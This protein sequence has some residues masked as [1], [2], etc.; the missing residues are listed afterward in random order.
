MSD[1]AQMTARTAMVDAKGMVSRP[2]FMFFDNIRTKVNIL[3]S[4]ITTSATAGAATAL[5]A[6]PEGYITIKLDGEDYKVPF[7][8]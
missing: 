8:K 7:Y 2:W 3:T 4:R 1:D 5:P 6:T